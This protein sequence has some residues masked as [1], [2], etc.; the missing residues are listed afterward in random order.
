M[1][2]PTNLV[3]SQLSPSFGLNQRT[4]SPS[5]SPEINMM[6]M[7]NRNDDKTTDM[8]KIDEIHRAVTLGN[9]RNVQQLID[10]KRLAYCRDQMGATP[11]H[12]AVIYGQKEIIEYFLDRFPSTIHTRD[13]STFLANLGPS[14]RKAFL[15]RQ[16][17]LVQCHGNLF[18]LTQIFF[19]CY[20]NRDL[21]QGGWQLGDKR[22]RTPL[23][24]AAVLPESADLYRMLAEA[25]ADEKALDMFGKKPEDYLNHQDGVSVVVLRES[26]IVTRPLG[27]R[28]SRKS[29]SRMIDPQSW[30]KIHSSS[31]K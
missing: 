22:G 11:L 27:Q 17:S 1:M 4:G 14:I 12:K 29:A 3:N 20:S 25:G 8:V 26:A 31:K 30:S 21:H 10:R 6:L 2:R 15:D 28:R 13:N 19:D 7:S 18:Q 24:Y 9:L 16:T 23:H 5:L